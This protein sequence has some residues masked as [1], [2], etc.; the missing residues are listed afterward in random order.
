M[1]SSRIRLL[2][3][4]LFLWYG[5]CKNND[6]QNQI[7]IRLGIPPSGGPLC[8]G[9]FRIWTRDN[10]II[11]RANGRSSRFWTWSTWTSNTPCSLKKLTMHHR[12]DLSSTNKINVQT[13]STLISLKSSF[14]QSLI[15]TILE[16]FSMKSY[17]GMNAFWI[18]NFGT[19]AILKFY[20]SITNLRKN[21]N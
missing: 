16:I 17:L 11:V 6:F 14:S 4:I 8:F 12:V 3:H 7:E 13:I 9:S 20:W 21:R 1:L 15:F 2:M 19:F 5:F 10:C 18:G